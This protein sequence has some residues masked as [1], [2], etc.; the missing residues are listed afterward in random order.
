MTRTIV[1]CCSRGES[2][3]EWNANAGPLRGFRSFTRRLCSATEAWMAVGQEAQLRVIQSSPRGTAMPLYRRCTHLPGAFPLHRARASGTRELKR[4]TW[5]RE[6]E[7]VSAGFHR[8][9]WECDTSFSSDALLRFRIVTQPSFSRPRH[10]RAPRQRESM[11]MRALPC[12]VRAPRE[13][14]EER[15]RWND[16]WEYIISANADQNLC[17]AML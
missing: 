9:L 14:R 1:D 11:S 17:N 16:D 15:E 2:S 4:G 7:D 5:G 6:R 10:P 8:H 13:K 3:Y 12:R